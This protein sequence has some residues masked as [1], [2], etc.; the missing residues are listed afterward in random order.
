MTISVELNNDDTK[1]FEQ[2]A[3]THNIT[4]SE[5]VRNAVI[6][7]I[8]DEYDLALQFKEEIIPYA[9]EYYLG[10]ADDEDDLGPEDEEEEE[11]EDEV[12]KQPKN[13]GPKK[14][15]FHGKKKY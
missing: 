9:I 3:K 10:I 11:E 1:L 14:C 6:E 2:Y 15:G 4:L 7:K 8:E 12:E 5:L 13:K